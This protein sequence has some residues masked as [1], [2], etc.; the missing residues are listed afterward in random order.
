M[1]LSL[2]V[3]AFLLSV[4]SFAQ[5]A[6]KGLVISKT[7][8]QPLIGAAILEAGTTSGT[9]TSMD[10]DFSL[11]L[12]NGEHKLEISYIGFITVNLSLKVTDGAFDLLSY[13]NGE[14]SLQD[15]FLTVKLNEDANFLASSKVTGRK[16][17]ESLQSLQKERITS[18]FAIENLGSKEMSLKGLSDAGESVAKISGISIADAGQLIVRGLG[19][20]YSTTTLN[21]LPIASPNP[22]NK[23]IPLDIFP[24]TT[25]QNVTVNK[26]YEVSSFADYSGAHIDIGTK[27]SSADYLAFSVGTVGL[28]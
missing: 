11:S 5:S 14:V 27:S 16:S 15:G 18:R 22:D 23:L 21:S 19:D 4:T 13:D 10:G 24:S 6:V 8:S 1:K 12:T 26:V 2:T 7:D 28:F 20:R 25:I 3:I 17:L 9:V